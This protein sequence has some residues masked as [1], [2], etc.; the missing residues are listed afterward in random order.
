MVNFW[1]KD[2][3]SL[4]ELIVTVMDVVCYVRIDIPSTI[5][6]TEPL[7]L[8]RFYV[9]INLHEKKWLLCCCY[10]GNKNSIK[11]HLEILHK[12]LALY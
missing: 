3:A 8:E 4:I 7:T 9:E 6:T 10:N 5:L 11:S 2:I 1:L 12:G